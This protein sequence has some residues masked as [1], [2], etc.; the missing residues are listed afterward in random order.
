M[1]AMGVRALKAT[2]SAQ[3]KRVEAGTTITV[4]DRGRSI[5][6]LGPIRAAAPHVAW[7]AEMVAE[8]RARWNGGKPVGLQPRLRSKGRPTSQMVLEDRR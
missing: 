5:A 1:Q 6:I 2:L 3:L 7:A 4:T 8:G